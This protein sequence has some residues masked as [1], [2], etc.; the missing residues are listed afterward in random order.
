MV[1]E[2][3]AGSADRERPNIIVILSD[4]QQN[5]SLGAMPFTSSRK[6]WV[7]FSSA[8]VNTAL[9]CPS[10]A[11]LLTGRTSERHGILSNSETAEFNGQ[12]TIADWLNE[13]GYQTGFVGK[14][15][16]KFPWDEAAT[17]IPTG[18]DYWAA[19]S[20]KQGYWD[21]TLNDNGTLVDRKG[22]DS[23]STDVFAEKMVEFID[24]AE[25]DRPL[26]GLVSFFGP[27]S[28]WTPAPR[29]REAEVDELEETEAFIEKNVRDKPTWVQNLPIPDIGQLRE[30]RIRH[31]RTLL[32]IDQGVRAIFKALKRR[33]ELDNTLI[34]YSSDHGIG[35]GDHRY[36]KKTCGYEICSRVPLLIRAPGVKART[37]EAVVGNID[38]T[39][40]FADYAGIETGETVDGRSLRKLLLG[41]RDVVHEKGIYLR[42]AQGS[43]ERIFAGIRT[44][45]WK[46]LNYGRAEERELYNLERDPDEVK[47]LLAANRARWVRKADELHEQMD[48]VR[49]TPSKVR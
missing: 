49:K 46:Y 30:Q 6:R 38:F 9:C 11:T 37:E 42:R 35:L 13:S 24:T 27:H 19:Y 40:T 12:S 34:V 14:Y 48:D 28:P 1:S 8:M 36:T 3:E 25:T 7:D 39:P 43:G 23:Y 15:L 33:G 20:G 32:S 29:D 17:F 21:Y 47:N 2:A 4:D 18:W 10:R 22:E 16:N 26:F 44:E 31:Q 45:K 41:R 5:S